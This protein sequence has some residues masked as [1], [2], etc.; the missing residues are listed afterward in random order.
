MCILDARTLLK[1]CVEKFSGI[2]LGAANEA[3]RNIIVLPIW[4][5]VTGFCGKAV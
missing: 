1:C 4:E 2:H 3:Q 5:W